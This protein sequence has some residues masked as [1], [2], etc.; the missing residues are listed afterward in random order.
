M[1]KN[2]KT[3]EIAQCND[4]KTTAHAYKKKRKTKNKKK[5]HTGKVGSLWSSAIMQH[6]KANHRKKYIHT[7]T[8]YVNEAK[9]NNLNTENNTNTNTNTNT[10]ESINLKQ[11]HF[12]SVINIHYLLDHSDTTLMFDENAIRNRANYF[13]GDDLD[14]LNSTIAHIACFV[15][16]FTHFSFVF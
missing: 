13:Y 3:C 14:F 7:W 5:T 10:N 8:Q 16:F 6:I 4:F 12:Y 15:L 11:P 2:E 9:L 1:K